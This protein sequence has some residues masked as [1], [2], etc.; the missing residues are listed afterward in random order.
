MNHQ[1]GGLGGRVVTYFHANKLFGHHNGMEDVLQVCSNRSSPLLPLAFPPV[2]LEVCPLITGRGFGEHFCS[3][4]GSGRSPAVK[5]Y[6][7][8]FRLKISPMVVLGAAAAS[9]KI[10]A[11]TRVTITASPSSKIHAHF[12]ASTAPSARA[13]ALQSIIK[14]SKRACHVVPYSP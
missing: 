10:R 11:T 8:N 12:R 13:K 9:Q 2:P 6:L 5:R 4:I 7:V 3:P 1:T 14:R